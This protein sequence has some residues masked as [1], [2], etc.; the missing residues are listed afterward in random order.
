MKYLITIWLVAMYAA[1]GAPGEKGKTL[2]VGEIEG[3]DNRI[4]TY[5][6]NSLRGKIDSTTTDANGQFKLLVDNMS[7]DF[8]KLSVDGQSVILAMDSTH[9]VGIRGNISDLKRTYEIE[10]SKD[11]QLLSEYTKR[12]LKFRTAKDSITSSIS[13]RTEP[14]TTADMQAYND[15]NNANV[16]EFYDYLIEFVDINSSSPAAIMASNNLEPV[17]ELERLNKLKTD[18]KEVMPTSNAYLSLK[19]KIADAERK[20]QVLAQQNA[21][22]AAS[23][24]GN[25]APEIELNDPDG[26]PVALSSLRG[27]YVLVDF[28]ASWCGPCRRENPNVVKMYNKYKDDG[29]EIFGVSLDSTKDRWLRAIKDDNLT[30]THVSDLAKWNSVAARDYGVRSIPHTVLLDNNR[31]IMAVKLRGAQLEEKLAEIFGH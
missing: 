21:A 29:F 16:K 30:W 9:Q 7:L 13:S 28:W 10:G 14:P 25:D 4:V 24:V 15:A 26:T 23:G 6:N 18:L 19:K 17:A 12:D 8:Y 11:S 22:S 3:A 1:C 20:K 5:Q 27:K 2:I 31:K